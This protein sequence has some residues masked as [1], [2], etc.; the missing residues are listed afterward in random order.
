MSITFRIGLGATALLALTAT[1]AS[2]QTIDPVFAGNYTW[3]S[4]GSVPGVPTSYGGLNFLPGDP[5]TLLIGGSAS[6]TAGAVYRIGL[7]RDAQNNI[8]GFSGTGTLQASA[9]HVDGGVEFAGNGVL[10]VT[11]WPDNLLYQL[12]PGSAAP[13]HTTTLTDLGVSSSTGSVR[14]VPVGFAGAGRLKIISYSFS[15]WYDADLT[16][17]GDTGLYNVALSQTLPVALSSGP[18]GA[19]YIAGTNPQ[20]AHDSVLISEYNTGRISAYQIDANG[21][22]DPTTRRTFMTGISGAEGAAIDPLTGHFL[23]S[24]YGG[25]NRVIV[26]RG[27][28]PPPSCPCDTNGDAVL[29]SQDF[30]DFLTAFFSSAPS[31]DF[32][33]D[34]V[35][36]SQ[37][38]FDFLACFFTPP[39]GCQ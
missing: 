21:D 6:L 37:D 4:L 27:F 12:R 36:N 14:I 8:T 39:T 38:F 26:V 20:F 23:F 1:G 3:A 13:D 9:P 5:N 10:L 25:G 22:P 17:D 24:T 33:G 35:I 15:T 30:F 11:T 16:L 31:A 32:N 18:E 28:I 19:V 2:A 29:N 34:T 7:T